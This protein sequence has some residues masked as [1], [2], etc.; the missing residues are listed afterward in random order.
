NHIYRTPFA[1]AVMGLICLGCALQ[2]AEKP[3]ARAVRTETLEFATD[4]QGC[5]INGIESYFVVSYDPETSRFRGT[6]HL[7]NSTRI[8]KSFGCFIGFFRHLKFFD[9]EGNPL[10]PDTVPQMKEPFF[11]I[12]PLSPLAHT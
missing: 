1:I 8:S 12:I 2:R 4:L 5:T 11:E 6:V 9:L 7:S 10:I 3:V